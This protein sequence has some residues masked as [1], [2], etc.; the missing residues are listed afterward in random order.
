VKAGISARIADNR[1]YP[2]RINPGVNRGYI[3]V[4]N[5]FNSN[6]IDPKTFKLVNVTGASGM[7]IYRGDNFPAALSGTAFVTEPC[8]NLVTALSVKDGDGKLVGGH[9]YKER[10]FLASTDERFRPV[11]AFTAPDGSL[12]IL[13]MYHGIIQHKTYVTSYL[14]KQILSRKL[15]GPPNG[16]GRIYRIRHQDKPRGPA[17]R[18]EDLAAARLVPYLSHPNGWWRD[19]A[20]RLIVERGDASLAKPLE[21][22]LTDSAK[23]LGQ[24]HAL[25]T[26]EGLG[27]LA[28]DH[29]G[30]LLESGNDKLAS[31]ALFAAVSLPPLGRQEVAAAAK[32][33]RAGKESAI[34]L[35]RLLAEA[36]DPK[37]LDAL[38]TVLQEHGG[39]PLVR[40]AAFAG[41]EGHEAVFLGVNNGRYQDK[42]FLKWLEE[43]LNKNLKKVE[44]PRIEGEHLASYQ[45]GEKLYMGRAACIGCHGA[46]GN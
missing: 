39:R 12:Y 34:Y 27:L 6:T 14:R 37:A 18:L 3:N 17:P 41:L 30:Y 38:V 11:N 9:L 36:A 8:G 2:I 7:A 45:R 40:E 4:L 23:P 25:W 44:P 5:G 21:A 33:F 24:I 31:S 35:A 22:T 42:D 10:E 43:A 26:L 28:P 13:D 1:V 46:D 20:Q 19:T 16:H 29:I 15:D 32:S